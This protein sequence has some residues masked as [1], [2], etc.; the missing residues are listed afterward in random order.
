[1]R[2]HSH[3]DSLDIHNSDVPSTLRC[4]LDAVPRIDPLELGSR[5]RSFPCTPG[6]AVA[7]WQL[8]TRRSHDQQLN[9]NRVLRIAC[10]A[11]T[12]LTRCMFEWEEVSPMLSGSFAGASCTF[13]NGPFF[14]RGQWSRQS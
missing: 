14:E 5:M 1:M 11:H 12:Q 2:T 6:L 4:V 8:D 3:I 9:M 7:R 13:Q 10:A